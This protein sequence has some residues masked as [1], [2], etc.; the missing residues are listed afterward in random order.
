MSILI[1]ELKHQKSESKNRVLDDRF[2]TKCDQE[3]IAR[4]VVDIAGI[5]DGARGQRYR[6]AFATTKNKSKYEKPNESGLMSRINLLPRELLLKT[7]PVDYADWN[8]DPLVGFISRK[9][10]ELVRFLLKKNKLDRL[11]EVGYGSGIFMPDI[12]QYCNE[13]HGIDVHQHDRAVEKV[14]SGV[15]VG[16]TLRA[17]TA[18]S[19]PYGDNYFGAI[20]CVSVLEFIDDLDA[21]MREMRRVLRPEGVL[22]AVTPTSSAIADLG[23]RVLTGKRAEDDF[24]GRRQRV[25]PMLRK[26]FAEVKSIGWP[27]FPVL[28]RA[29]LMR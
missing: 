29:F 6:H 5:G 27:R 3:P 28:Y 24:A 23:L 8:S 7:G 25:I 16:A 1:G 12:V 4:I 14:L 2:D 26:Y 17:G 13:L 11:L 19:M 22:V 15:G 10:F 18:E 20:V 9:R 21:A